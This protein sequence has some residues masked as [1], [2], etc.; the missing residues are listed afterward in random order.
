RFEDPPAPS[1]IEDAKRQY[2]LTD[3]RFEPVSAPL[4]EG[5][6]VRHRIMGE[7]TVIKVD[8]K[9]QIYRVRFDELDTDRN[10]SFRAGL[11]KI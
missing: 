8:L 3:S 6:R 4:A 2:A 5:D 1:L 9:K 10:I 11:Q 7:G